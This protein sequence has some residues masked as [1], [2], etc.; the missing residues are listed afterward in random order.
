MA[1]DAKNKSIVDKMRVSERWRAVRKTEKERYCRHLHQSTSPCTARPTCERKILSI[2][3][4]GLEETRRKT[5]PRREQASD[6]RLGAGG[7]GESRLELPRMG[8]EHAQDTR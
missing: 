1:A 2:G 4:A 8:L 7:V 6:G 5:W 3:E